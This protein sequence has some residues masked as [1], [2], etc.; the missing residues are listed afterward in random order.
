MLLLLQTCSPLEMLAE[1]RDSIFFRKARC[2][3]SISQVLLSHLGFGTPLAW[4]RVPALLCPVPPWRVN[5]GNISMAALAPL[6]CP[7]A[8]APSFPG[9]TQHG[10][11]AWPH[12]E[13]GPW[14]P[15]WQPVPR[16]A[17]AAPAGWAGAAQTQEYLLC[18]SLTQSGGLLT[19]FFNLIAPEPCREAA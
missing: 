19:G 12:T 5:P 1:I 8:W 14:G 15:K 13:R 6:Q 2:S 4:C 3:V 17:P 10:T 11:P 18:L 9:L 16:W 7:S